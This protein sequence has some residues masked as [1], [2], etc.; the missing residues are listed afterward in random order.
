MHRSNVY[1][2][3]NSYFLLHFEENHMIG[4]HMVALCTVYRTAVSVISL[5]FTSMHSGQCYGS[6][7]VWL[8]K[9]F[10]SSVGIKK[11]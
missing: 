8:Y 4:I 1:L 7:K 5:L 9:F 3:V 11:I 6:F 2:F 10:L